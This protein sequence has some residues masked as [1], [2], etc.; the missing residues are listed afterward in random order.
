LKKEKK[1][2]NILNE[3]GR[4]RMKNSFIFIPLGIGLFLLSSACNNQSRYDIEGI[5]HFYEYREPEYYLDLTYTFVGTEK[6]GQLDF[7]TMAGI[8]GEYTVDADQ[9]FFR[10]TAGRGIM[11]NVHEYT[12][13]FITNNLMKGTLKGE[14]I[15][16]GQVTLAWSG[17]WNARRVE[18]RAPRAIF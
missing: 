6:Q 16:M 1:R 12:G 2:F 11:W 14:H 13:A 5:W 8:S 7:G 3:E 4:D 18:G 15:E 10:V 9:V 17:V